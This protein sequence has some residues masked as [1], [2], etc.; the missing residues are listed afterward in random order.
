M[1]DPKAHA[2]LLKRLREQHQET[3]K[4]TQAHLKATQTIRRKITAAMK[5]KALTIPE[6]A[7]TAELAPD[8]VLWHIAALRKYGLV[9]EAG[10]ED[11]YYRY[12]LAEES[13]R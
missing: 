11:G 10:Q 5:G 7:T 8:Q 9:A 3:V 4:A 12:T 1:V 6:L 2:Q 13:K